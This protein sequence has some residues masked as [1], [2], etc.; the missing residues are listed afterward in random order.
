MKYPVARRDHQVDT[1]HGIPVEDPYR[2]LEDKSSPET[3]QWIAAQ[4]ALTKQAL[5]R[6]PGRKDLQKDIAAMYHYDQQSIE[7]IRGK[8]RFYT[9]RLAGKEQSHLNVIG[10][11]G[12]TRTLV[13]PLK[14]QPSGRCPLY[15]CSKLPC[16]GRIC[17]CIVVTCCHEEG[18]IC[19]SLHN[20]V[21]WGILS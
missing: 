20:M 10:P 12:K 13:D 21:V 3:Q 8:Y 16:M 11:D 15:C 19:C 17:P 9:E 6:T 4:D 14:L 2:W 5:S 7:Y 18:R 1:Y